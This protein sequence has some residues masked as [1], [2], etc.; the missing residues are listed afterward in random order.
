[1]RTPMTLLGLVLMAAPGLAEDSGPPTGRPAKHRITAVTVY[2]G[3]ALVTREVEV[4]DGAGAMELLVSPL[5]PQTLAG[6]PYAEG[7]DGIRVLNTRYRTIA[8]KEDTREEVRKLAESLKQLQALAQKVQADIQLAADHQQFLAKLEGFTG[9]TMQHLTDKGVMNADAVIALSKF[10]MQT[11]AERAREAVT[12][13]QQLQDVNAQTE[14]TQR[15]L[16]EKTAGVSR[17]ERVA[18]ITVD[19]ANAAAGRVRLNYLVGAVHWQ[20][21]Y[22]FRAGKA[23]E[24]VQLE[25]LA[26][27]QQQTGED[28][29]NVTLALSTAQP[30]LHAAPP[31]LKMLEVSVV[32]VGGKA[33]AQAAGRALP[34]GANVYRELKSRADAGRAQ[35]QMFQNVQ[36]WADAAKVIN[37]AAACE[38]TG[39]LLASRDDV[40]SARQELAESVPEGPSVTYRLRGQLSLPSRNDEQ[41]MEVAR[42][43]LPPEFYYKAVPVLTP[44]VYRQADLVNRSEYV[45]FPGESTMYVG[46]DFVGRMRL[47]LVAIGKPFSVSFGVDPQIQVQR[48]MVNKNRVTSGGNQVLSFDYRIHVNS[49]K[50]EPAKVQVWDRLPRGEQQTVAVSLVSHKPELSADALYLREERPKNLLRWDVTV[51]PGQSGEKALTIDYAY[52]LE[53]DKQLQIGAVV[54]K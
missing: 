25:Y 40:A 15:Q 53:L 28:W 7:T 17:T 18:V 49:F 13:Q 1:M 30:L 32:P 6:S 16:A 2:Q 33:P 26:G 3:N 31:D 54:A 41:V 44:H 23:N 34:E 48:A 29:A 42:L 38:Q 35:G 46:T 51:Q 37:E 24:P 20:P 19:K 52:R 12:L 4:P 47:P 50:T 8:I 9:V 45:L 39:E 14:F 27:V 11:K 10:I 22:R 21:K 43:E 5:P 36:N